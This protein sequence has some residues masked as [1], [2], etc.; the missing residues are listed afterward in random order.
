MLDVVSEIDFLCSDD[1]DQRN[2]T[3]KLQIR[4]SKNSVTEIQTK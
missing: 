2:V 4:L 3:K 1:N